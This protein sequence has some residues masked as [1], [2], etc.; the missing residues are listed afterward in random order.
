M[1]RVKWASRL[2][3]I[4]AIFAVVAVIALLVMGKISTQGQAPGVVDGRLT[5]C[6]DMPNC[7]CSEYPND[8]AH[9]IRALELP[10]Q[11]AKNDNAMIIA[12]ITESGG[13]IIAEQADYIAATF[14]S[15][16]FGFVDDL[17][18]RFDIDAG[19]IHF[20][21]ASRVGYGDMGINR[22]RVESI[23]LQFKQNYANN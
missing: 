7:V 1:S 12:I 2:I 16:M 5:R 4:L 15:T 13:V 19:L 17:E 9:Y 8:S 22:K 18:I 23:Q 21:S 20:R 10:E 6:P 14:A 3:T 11:F